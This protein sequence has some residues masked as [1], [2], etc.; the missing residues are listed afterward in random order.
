MMLAE[1]ANEKHERYPPQMYAYVGV[2]VNN[3]A[4]L[5]IDT[6]KPKHFAR[7]NFTGELR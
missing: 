5:W 6:N 7:P 4:V 1:I 2:C 3:T